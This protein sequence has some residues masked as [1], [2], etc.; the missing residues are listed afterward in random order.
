MKP[1]SET[2]KKRTKS[3]DV[4][5]K[6]ARSVSFDLDCLSD[7]R[8]ISKDRERYIKNISKKALAAAINI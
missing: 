7:E 6:V 2:S 5:V 8:Q 3:E 1:F 4:A